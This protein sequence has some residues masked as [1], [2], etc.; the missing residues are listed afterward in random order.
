MSLAEAL[1]VQREGRAPEGLSRHLWRSALPALVV[2][3]LLCCAGK[4]LAPAVV[5]VVVLALPLLLGSLVLGP[6]SL[7]WFVGFVMAAALVISLLDGE[8]GPRRV[9][10]VGTLVAMAGVVLVI[11]R[12]R[13]SL[14]VGALTGESMLV[15]LRDRILRQ[16][17]VPPLPEGWTVVSQLRSAGG[18]A[19]AGD[20]VVVGRDDSQ[21]RLD[22]AV[23]DVSGKGEEA[24]TRALL[25]S[26]A[27]G[28]LLTALPPERFLPAANDFL[29][30]Q[31]WPEGFASAVHLTLDLDTGHYELRHAG[32]PPAVVVPARGP[33]LVDHE[34]EGPVLGLF[35]AAHFE[36]H[37]GQLASGAAILLYTDGM[38][39]A[40]DLDLDDGIA[41][42]VRSARPVLHS[43][44]DQH[45]VA[46]LVDRIGSHDDDRCL[47]IVRRA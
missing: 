26:G 4:A 9:A 40:R 22:L 46:N 5:P 23:V 39:E 27:M 30:H 37:R 28:A 34:S 35:P 31:E 7:P 3:V 15:D 32:H 1:R 12:W 42:L 19:F 21:R 14:G 33:E 25:L 20:F 45:A 29:L 11:S 17:S 36:V 44:L 41:R 47:V 2:M 24:G 18:T 38:V 6:R 16:G 10:S 8:L 13:S 43:E